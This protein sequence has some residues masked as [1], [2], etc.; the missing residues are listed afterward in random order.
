[1]AHT[2][3]LLVDLQDLSETTLILLGFFLVVFICQK[4]DLVVRPHNAASHACPDVL[5]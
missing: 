4:L 5:L 2:L 3:V 1:M